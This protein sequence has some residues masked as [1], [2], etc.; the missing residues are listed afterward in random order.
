MI[1][2]ERHDSFAIITLNCPE[3]LNQ[4]TPGMLL[5][6]FETLDKIENE[7][8]LR[9]V[10]LT[11]AGHEA[12][13]A[14]ANVDKTA[15]S[16]SHEASEHLRRSLVVCNR[17]RGCPIPVI[18]AV[19]GLAS[20][21]GC[22]LAFSCHLIIAG[23]NAT[24]LL[25][26]TKSQWVHVYG[27]ASRPECEGNVE[28]SDI[29][30]PVGESSA[31]MALSKGFINRVVDPASLL[32]EAKSLAGEIALLAPRAITA[33]IRAVASG[34]E[35]PLDEALVIEAELFASLF[36]TEDMREGTRAFLEKRRPV[37]RGS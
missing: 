1:L 13:C 24:F 10:I 15:E 7:P 25:P 30:L 6:L 11:G 16:D 20:G 3:K 9:S 37:F 14:D 28:I 4:L 29:S 34:L 22:A 17:I 18:A 26:A 35:L 12:F 27:K 5:A 8:H 32:S 33:F 19:N 21:T 23:S 31:K 2:Y 36:A